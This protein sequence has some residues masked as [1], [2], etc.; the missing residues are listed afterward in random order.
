MMVQGLMTGE[1]AG[2][3]VDVRGLRCRSAVNP[4]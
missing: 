3:R 1:C 2:F 4:G